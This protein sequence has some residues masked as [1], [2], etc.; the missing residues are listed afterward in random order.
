[1]SRVDLLALLADYRARFPGE[2]DVVARVESLLAAPRCFARDFFSPGHIT[3]SAWLVDRTGERVLLTHHRKLGRWFQLGGH[4]D[5]DENVLRVA[6]REAEEE[7]G[8]EVE[9]VGR[10]LFDLDIHEIPTI[11]S[12]P[13]HLHFD[14]RCAFRVSG[15]DV[16][17]VSDE[18][19]ALSWVPLEAFESFTDEVSMRRMAAKWRAAIDK[20]RSRH[21]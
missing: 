14:L 9:P 16:F 12:D 15:N 21:L 20:E 13:T 17:A 7:S 5:G 1:M 10:G 3:G 18:S 19:H 11:G 6:W 2:A 8:L 4:A